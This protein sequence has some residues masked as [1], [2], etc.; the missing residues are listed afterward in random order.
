MTLRSALKT[1]V[2][3]SVFVGTLLAGGYLV[4][5]NVLEGGNRVQAEPSQAP[6][7][8]PVPVMS[9]RAVPSR[10]WSEHSGRLTAIESVELRPQVSGT[11]QDIRFEDG[12]L[13]S[14]GD[15]LVVIDPR[16][17]EAAVAEA[18]AELEAARHN[19]DYAIKQL[20]RAKQLVGKGHISR[21]V[22]DERVNDHTVA[23]TRV[24]SAAA[25]LQMAEIDLD[26][27]YVKAPIS[28]RLSRAEIT[29][30]NLVEAGSNAPILTTIVASEGIY[31][32]FDVDERT[33]L[34]QRHSAA[35]TGQDKTAMP[36]ELIID[37]GEERVYQGHIH[38]FDNQ[39]DPTTGT[40]RTRA[41]FANDDGSLLPGMFAALRLGAPEA[42]EV[43]LLD[44]KEIGTDQ[45]RKF[46]YLVDENSQVS[47][48][49][50]TLGAAVEGQRVITSGLKVGDQVILGGLMKVRP[51]MPVAPQ[52]VEAEAPV[53]LSDNQTA[54]ATAAN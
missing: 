17:F 44:A 18:K 11:I 16:P 37:A 9:V 7:A 47:Y 22:L 3:G 49:E 30:G 2:Y 42:E 13:V 28:G 41:I 4:K 6:Q 27:A 40:I 50:V 43:I 19:V 8:M 35:S 38:S 46:V 51:G 26:F 10:I 14:K 23:I 34:R 29:V 20:D 52:P 48:R 5:T 25:Q 24:S 31:A 21:S 39:I 36:V 15:I 1:L 53:L 33:Y 12:Q 32:D 54:E 45:D